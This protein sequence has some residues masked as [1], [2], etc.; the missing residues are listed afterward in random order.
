[1]KK[2]ICAAVAIVIL[3]GTIYGAQSGYMVE[4]RNGAVVLAEEGTTILEDNFTKASD[5][6]QKV[7]NHGNF[8]KLDYTPEG[9][10]LTNRMKKQCDTAW[11]LVS[12][13]LPLPTGSDSYT[14]VL[15]LRSTVKTQRASGNGSFANAIVWLNANGD[16]I[17]DKGTRF[18]YD[19]RSEVMHSVTYRGIIPKTAVSCVVHLGFDKPNINQGEYLLL[20]GIKF[21]CWKKGEGKPASSGYYISEPLFGGH[22]NLSWTEEMPTGCTATLQVAQL[23]AQGQPVFCGP[24][25][26]PGTKYLKPGPLPAFAGTAEQILIRAELTGDGHSSPE[27]KNIRV[28]EKVLKI[29]LSGKAQDVNLISVTQISA[30]PEQD[31]T[32]PLRFRV[33]A[34][35][36]PDWKTMQ[37][38]LDRKNVTSGITRTGNEISIAPAGGS[39][40]EGLHEYTVFLT[41]RGGVKRK[42]NKAFY[43]GKLEIPMGNSVSL[44]DDG[45]VL[46]GGKPFF[47]I[48]IYAVCEREF[49]GNNIDKAFN[50]LK[51]AGFNFAHTYTSIN[52]AFG[53]R[54]FRAAEKYGFKIFVSPC[55][56]LSNIVKWS[57][58]PALLSWYI[59]DDTADHHTPEGLTDMDRNIKAINP[60]CLTCQADDIAGG[61]YL[62][63]INSTDAFLPEIY[64][65]QKN[66]AR[67]AQNCV[68][69]VVLSMKTFHRDLKLTNQ[70]RSKEGK[71]PVV[72]TCWALVQHFK[73]W[74][75]ERFP[76]EKE[77]RAMSYAAIAA[78]AHGITW[79]TYGGF[80]NPEKKTANYGITS[81]PEVWKEITTLT[82]ELNRLQDVFTERSVP[83]PDFR[84]LSGPHSDP[85]GNASI[86]RIAKNHQGKTYVLA[87][88]SRLAEIKTVFDPGKKRDITDWFSGERLPSGPDGT[89]ITFEPFGVKILVL[90]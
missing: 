72:K 90:D 12:R 22:G 88:N 18:Q 57:K 49:N 66:T 7:N 44:R 69:H 67:D 13:V 58:S 71:P 21:S 24:D 46:I 64:P 1:M 40:S 2:T 32:A 26:T 87:V 56:K 3:S 20:G 9:V 47:P 62:A 84:I 36:T 61:R 31:L 15:K 83:C 63:F 16:P 17:T 35:S 4:I 52:D 79:Y 73:G 68:A 38:V 55:G 86:T 14:L 53:D 37:I 76:T 43:R 41:D 10:M 27:L 30:S 11:G 50:D 82:G 28:R 19:S 81:S 60:Y 39:F 33:D 54:F 74:G 48:G 42:F 34:D 65:I 5:V 51:A 70:R 59:G 6:W 85:L 45:I 29:S 80:Q 23:P 75:W 89:P 25:G 77:L 78:G 8:I